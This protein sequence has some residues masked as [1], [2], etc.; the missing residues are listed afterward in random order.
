MTRQRVGWIVCEQQTLRGALGGGP[1]P[2]RGV[3]RARE[4][5]DCHFLITWSGERGNAG[6]CEARAGLPQRFIERTSGSGPT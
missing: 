4:C 5:L 1:A 3:V 6:W 2:G